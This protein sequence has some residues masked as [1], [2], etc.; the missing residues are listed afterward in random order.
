MADVYDALKP[1]LY[2]S[3]CFGLAPFTFDS[4]ARRLKISKPGLAFSALVLLLY[5]GTSGWVVY[6]LMF[7]NLDK[8]DRNNITEVNEACQVACEVG[9]TIITIL[10]AII[11]RN[12]VLIVVNNIHQINGEMK[13]LQISIPYGSMMKKSLIQI[14]CLLAYIVFLSIHKVVVW[15]DDKDRQQVQVWIASLTP[16]IYNYLMEIQFLTG[17]LLLKAHF[18]AL[19]DYLITFSANEKRAFDSEKENDF[20]DAIDTLIG[21]QLIAWDGHFTRLKPRKD[22]TVPEKHVQLANIKVCL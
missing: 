10:M 16:A 21:P 13:K 17:A 3:T 15:F 11:Q 6:N 12:K 19:N 20:V 7:K 22:Q 2:V 8:K 4:E 14:V 5:G 1:N 18:K 9:V